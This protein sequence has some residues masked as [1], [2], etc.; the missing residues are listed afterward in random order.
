MLMLRKNKTILHW[1]TFYAF[2][3]VSMW[4]VFGEAKTAA[5]K[6]RDKYREK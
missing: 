2:Y 3:V 4:M 6:E 1:I 5:S